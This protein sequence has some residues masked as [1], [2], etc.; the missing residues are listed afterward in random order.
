MIPDKIINL[1]GTEETAHQVKVRD[2]IIEM[3]PDMKN[4]DAIQSTIRRSVLEYNLNSKE[5]LEHFGQFVFNVETKDKQFEEVE[6][7][8]LRMVRI[9]FSKNSPRKPPKVVVVGPPGSGRSTQA[10]KIAE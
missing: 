4:E 3:N 6:E 8:I 10:K 1:N 2:L 5:V 7:N 9:R